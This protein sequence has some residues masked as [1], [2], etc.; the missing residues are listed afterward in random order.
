MNAIKSRVRSDVMWPD[1][2]KTENIEGRSDAA[3]LSDA[4]CAW[5]CCHM[6]AEIPAS[7]GRIMVKIGDKLG[8]SATPDGCMALADKMRK[9]RE[10]R[11]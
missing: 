6:G 5:G 7:F 10:A 11:I 2:F 3:L 1:I 9:E 8:I 4:L